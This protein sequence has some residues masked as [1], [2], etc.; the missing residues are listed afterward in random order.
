MKFLTADQFKQM[1]TRQDRLNSVIDSEWNTNNYNW[2][3]YIKAEIMEFF[4][5][6]GY[7]HWKE[8][9]KTKSCTDMQARLE[10]VDIWH[11]L[12]S[13]IIQNAKNIDTSPETSFKEL[14]H[15]LGLRNFVPG[16]GTIHDIEILDH[17]RISNWDK[18]MYLYYALDACDWTWNDLYIAYIG[19]NVL[20]KFRQDNGYKQGTYQK[21]WYG[22]ED[23]V[24]LEAAVA[25]LVTEGIF[26][27]EE[28]YDHLQ[29][30]YNDYLCSLK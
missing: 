8:P 17:T 11:F 20:N 19:K 22:K 25:L 7:K 23:N 2:N 30:L 24:H 16:T 21:E 6:I 9:D 12:L 18:V 5:Y 27:P 4:E 3:L 13:S 26:S 10:L 1:W 14:E 15:A 29:D 28:L